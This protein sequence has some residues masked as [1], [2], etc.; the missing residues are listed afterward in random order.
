MRA[1]NRVNPAIQKRL[2]TERQKQKK[3]NNR[4]VVEEKRESSSSPIIKVLID[5]QYPP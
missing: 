4:E 5:Q 3:D 2:G 1:I